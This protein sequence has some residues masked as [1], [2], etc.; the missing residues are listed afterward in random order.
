MLD[1]PVF[2]YVPEPH[3]EFFNPADDVSEI[4][5]SADDFIERLLQVRGSDE[6]Q[7]RDR[8]AQQREKLAYLIANVDTPYAADRILDELE[9]F[10]LPDPEAKKAE[11]PKLGFLASL[12][13]SFRKWRKPDD[14]ERKARRRQKFPALSKDE[15]DWAVGQWVE[16]GLLGRHITIDRLS[17]RILLFH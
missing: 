7:L 4:V 10:E 2:S 12:R 9:R 13:R 15:A 1:R 14:E 8:F 3:V 11:E 6:A 16:G 17:E 5:T